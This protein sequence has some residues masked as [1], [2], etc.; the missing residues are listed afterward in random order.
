MGAVVVLPTQHRMHPH[1]ENCGKRL[2]NSNSM[3]MNVS[4][5]ELGGTKL[6][7]LTFHIQCACGTTWDLKKAIKP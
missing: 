3:M 6:E 7:G 4:S 1:C 5:D 2:P